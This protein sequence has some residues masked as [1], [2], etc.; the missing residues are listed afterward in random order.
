MNIQ[1]IMHFFLYYTVNQ[2]SELKKQKSVR[3]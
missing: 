3:H 2:Y 1:H